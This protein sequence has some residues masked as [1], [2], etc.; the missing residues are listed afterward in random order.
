MQKNVFK[1]LLKNNKYLPNK[2]KHL[3]SGESEVT[4]HAINVCAIYANCMFGNKTGYG[5]N[6]M[7]KI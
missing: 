5:R 2:N 6:E 7:T 3:K 4:V 1:F